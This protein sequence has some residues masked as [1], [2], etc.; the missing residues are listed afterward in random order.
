[1]KKI[2]LPIIS[3]LR[4]QTEEMLY[5]D[6][7]PPIFLSLEESKRLVLASSMPENGLYNYS[8]EYKDEKLF[9][10]PQDAHFDLYLHH[11]NGAIHQVLRPLPIQDGDHF[12]IDEAYGPE[13]SIKITG[14]NTQLSEQETSI[15]NNPQM[16]PTPQF[17]HDPVAPRH[18]TIAKKSVGWVY[19]LLLPLAL[20][21]F[22]NVIFS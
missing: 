13:W 11:K 4:K 20:A 6:L 10:S 22:L 21:A 1:M 7:S 18:K 9:I 5:R 17:K 14:Q 12:G 3:L 2:E 16:E 19:W 8:I 15:V